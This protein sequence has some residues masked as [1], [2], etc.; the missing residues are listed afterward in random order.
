MEMCR[1][2]C[3]DSAPYQSSEMAVRNRKLRKKLWLMENNGGMTPLQLATVHG[4]HQI[5]SL[6]LNMEVGRTAWI[7]SF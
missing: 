1:K 7:N 3:E 4:L 2:I 6:I 5:F